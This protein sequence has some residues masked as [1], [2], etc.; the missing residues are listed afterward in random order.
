MISKKEFEKLLKEDKFFTD[1]DKQ[2]EYRYPVVEY[3][4][5]NYGPKIIINGQPMDILLIRPIDDNNKL[6]VNQAFMSIKY[7]FDN[8]EFK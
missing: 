8:G 3:Y 4:I 1:F 6:L 5:H 2:W 7:R